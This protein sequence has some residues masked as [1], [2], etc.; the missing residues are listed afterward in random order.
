M[1]DA[2][3]ESRRDKIGFILSTR[4]MREPLLRDETFYKSLFE[5]YSNVSDEELNTE[6]EFYL[7]EV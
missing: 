5:V 1:I 6:F 4:A 3:K 2:T 7:G